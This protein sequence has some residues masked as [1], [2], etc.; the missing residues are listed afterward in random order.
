M[1]TISSGADGSLPFLD[2]Q[3]VAQALPWTLLIDAL[4][5]A[6]LTGDATA[7]ARLNYDMQHMNA[8][9]PTL[10]LMPA[11][12]P[13]LGVGTKLLTAYP[14]NARVGLPS[15]QGLYL[16]MEPNTGRP[17]AVLDGGELTARRTAA[18]SALA[19][20]Y[21]SRAD[22][23]CLLMVGTG[24]LSQHL[25]AAHAQVRPIERVWVWG[26]SHPRAEQAAQGLRA[27]GM[28]AEAVVSLQEAVTRA[29]IV[30]CATLSHE[31]LVRGDWL[32]PGTHLDLVGAYTPEMRE[33]D[34]HVFE[35]ANAV[36]CDT[37]EGALREAGDIVQAIEAGAFDAERLA[38]DLAALCRVQGVRDPADITVFKSVGMAVEDLAAAHLCVAWHAGRDG[39]P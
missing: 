20:R 17:Q 38:G 3:Q 5:R 26:R 32:R 31:P 19:S 28:N 30:S 22:S 21:L 39:A 35:R 4:R 34:A 1:S 36:W 9:V 27:Q 6:L 25:P 16:L 33:T 29:D 18:A 23:S 14:N 2:A 13:T 15:I 8:G 12:S 37:R 10:L 11:W 7:P 24:R